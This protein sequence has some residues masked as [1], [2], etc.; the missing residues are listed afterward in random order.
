MSYPASV[1][2]QDHVCCIRWLKAELGPDVE[3]GCSP[4][5]ARPVYFFD[6]FA[7]YKLRLVHLDI[8][9]LVLGVGEQIVNKLQQHFAGFRY[10]PQRPLILD[11][12]DS[13]SE[14]AVMPKIPLSGVR[15]S[16][17]MFAI[18]KDLA[19]LA[20]RAWSLAA[21]SSF[22]RSRTMS[23]K[24]RYCFSNSSAIR[25]KEYCSDT[26]SSVK[27]RG[28]LMSTCGGMSSLELREELGSSFPGPWLW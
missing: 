10:N 24:C 22:V 23:S 27:Y 21:S 11:G 19:W 6:D 14:T 28:C 18:N 9:H 17:V 1:S 16:W 15:S 26:S 12:S 2:Q 13:V 25:L 5:L 20:F 4:F 8:A 7:Q 3:F